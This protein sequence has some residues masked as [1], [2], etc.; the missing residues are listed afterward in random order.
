MLKL[1][2]MKHAGVL[3][4]TPAKRKLTK[5]SDKFSGLR[6]NYSGLMLSEPNKSTKSTNAHLSTNL[7]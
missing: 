3:L 7:W 4:G 6:S 1:N 2:A 5:G